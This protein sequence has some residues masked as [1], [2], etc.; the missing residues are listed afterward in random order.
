M[1]SHSITLLDIVCSK[2]FNS[3]CKNAVV[4]YSELSKGIYSQL[5][6][7]MLL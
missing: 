2:Q 3:Y 1:I 4:Y 7:N 5:R 6:Y